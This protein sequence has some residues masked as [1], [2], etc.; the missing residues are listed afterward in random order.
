[1]KKH[2]TEFYNLVNC[3]NELTEFKNTTQH[4]K[5]TMSQIIADRT[6]ENII[7]K[8]I[9]RCHNIMRDDE[10]IVGEK[11]L[12]DLMRLLF[13]RLLEPLIENKK[14]DITNKKHFDQKYHDKYDFLKWSVLKSKGNEVVQNNENLKFIWKRLLCSHPVFKYIFKQ[15]RFF[16]AHPETLYKCVDELDKIN[17]NVS[18]INYDVKGEIYEKFINNYS[19]NGGK[20]LGQY[21]TNLN[22]INMIH[23]LLDI[24]INPEIQYSGFDPCMGS[25]SFLTTLKKLYRSNIKVFGNE[26]EPDTFIFALMNAIFNFEQDI[27][28]IK[29][30]NSLHNLEPDIKYDLIMTNPPF[31]TKPRYDDIMQKYKL[32]YC[33]DLIIDEPDDKKLNK[34]VKVR[35][36]KIFP[37]KFN[38]GESLFLQLCMYKLKPNG[39]CA[40]VLPDGRMMFSGGNHRHLRKYLLHTFILEKILSVPGGA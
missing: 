23:S 1:M 19:G 21:F 5:I 14:I 24:K 36:K 34:K 12:H 4:K 26:I 2:N 9:D 30:G 32:N 16:N 40:I 11:A 29:I 13:L 22:Y 39:K 6:N 38:T 18:N 35:F 33:Q 8:I 17:I 25:A 7:I 27:D 31:G 15:D 20:Q 28:N 3:K 37:Y 10:S